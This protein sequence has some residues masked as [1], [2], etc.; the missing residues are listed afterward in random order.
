MIVFFFSFLLLMMFPI[1]RLCVQLDGCC[2]LVG[3]LFRRDQEKTNPFHPVSHMLAADMPAAWWLLSSAPQVNRRA[4]AWGNYR[5]FWP[6]LVSPAGAQFS[7]CFEFCVLA[8]GREL[9]ILDRSCWNK[10]LLGTGLGLRQV[11]CYMAAREGS[12]RS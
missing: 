1:I 9:Y 3:A 12:D 2:R 6:G 11:L 10:I 8:A 7:Q 5:I 4:G